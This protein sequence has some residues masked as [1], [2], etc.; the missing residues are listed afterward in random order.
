MHKLLQLKLRKD[1]KMH[2]YLR[3]NSSWYKDLNR[4]V[5]NY[6]KFV[7]SIKEMYKLRTSDKISEAI[8]NIDL[9]SS[10]LNVIK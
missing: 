1:S 10:V 4:S 7:S 5:K 3:L 8:D 2:N 9:I 6:D